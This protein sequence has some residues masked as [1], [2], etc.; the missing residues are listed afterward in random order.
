MYYPLVRDRNNGTVNI[1]CH[2]DMMV[3]EPVQVCTCSTL[4]RCMTAGMPLV[5]IQRT[6]AFPT[7]ISGQFF[8]MKPNIFLIF[9]GF[10]FSFEKRLQYS[11]IVAEIFWH[12]VDEQLSLGASNVFRNS[13][14]PWQKNKTYQTKISYNHCK[15]TQD[16]KLGH[17]FKHCVQYMTFPGKDCKCQS[18]KSEAATSTIYDWQSSQ[19]WIAANGRDF[20]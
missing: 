17:T 15:L 13:F 11:S 4:C 20:D 14:N 6:S 3:G 1:H 19:T 10:I 5:Q 2:Q 12:R 8:R 7:I 16:G 9:K 18:I